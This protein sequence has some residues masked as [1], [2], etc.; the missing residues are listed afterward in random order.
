MLTSSETPLYSYTEPFS[1]S[2]SSLEVDL[3]YPTDRIT[4]EI[5]EILFIHVESDTNFHKIDTRTIRFVI[6]DDVENCNLREKPIHKTAQNF[7]KEKRVKVMP[8]KNFM[9]LK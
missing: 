7:I 9:G 2:I 4:D 8:K 5:T 1:N 6:A 3:S